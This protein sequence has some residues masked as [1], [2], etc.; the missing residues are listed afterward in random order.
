MV[1]RFN[2]NSKMKDVL[3]NPVGHDLITA[4]IRQQNLKKS[5]FL[6]PLIKNAKLSQLAQL[7]KGVLDDAFVKTLCEKLNT[8]ANERV[9][10]SDKKNETWWKEAVIYQIYPRSFKDSM[11]MESGT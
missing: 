1:K 10:Q 2:V 8:Y 4:M 3:N 6:N 7:T 9:I 5:F 11:V